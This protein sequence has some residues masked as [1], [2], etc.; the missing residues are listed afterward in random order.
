MKSYSQAHHRRKYLQVNSLLAV[1]NTPFPYSQSVNFRPKLISEKSICRRETRCLQVPHL[2][3][4]IAPHIRGISGNWKCPAIDK[5]FSSSV[6][7]IFLIKFSPGTPEMVED[8]QEPWAWAELAQLD[9]SRYRHGLF[10]CHATVCDKHGCERYSCDEHRCNMGRCYE[11]PPSTLADSY[12]SICP[13][14]GSKTSR[15]GASS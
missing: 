14:I 9:D 6:Y 2:R 3:R 4:G 5:L 15:G 1:L 10:I 8:Q 11:V 12:N 7:G 13:R